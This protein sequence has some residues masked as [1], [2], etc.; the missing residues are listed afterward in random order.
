MFISLVPSAGGGASFQPLVVQGHVSTL[1]WAPAQQWVPSYLV[2]EIPAAPWIAVPQ[3]ESAGGRERDAFF[4]PTWLETLLEL[5]SE[6]RRAKNE[7]IAAGY[8]IPNWPKVLRMLLVE[9]EMR[10]G[11]L[12]IVEMHEGRASVKPIVKLLDERAKDTL[13]GRE[14]ITRRP[15]VNRVRQR[16]Q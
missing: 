14:N 13:G 1:G 8:L 2:R 15:P 11:V 4:I 5:G 6:M 9:R 3:R 16:P 12:A 10:K 7:I